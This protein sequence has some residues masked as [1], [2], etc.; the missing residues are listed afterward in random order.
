M[1]GKIELIDNIDNVAFYIVLHD[2]TNVF[3]RWSSGLSIIDRVCFICEEA[4][5]NTRKYLKIMKEG[6]NLAFHAQVIIKYI[7]VEVTEL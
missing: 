7:A 1:V 2:S 3:R 6:I 4:K 5:N